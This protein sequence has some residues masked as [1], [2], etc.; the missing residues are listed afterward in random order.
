MG[1]WTHILL[2]LHVCYTEASQVH[3]RHAEGELANCPPLSQPI[4]EPGQVTITVQVVGVETQGPDLWHVVE[5]GDQDTAD[6]VVVKGEDLQ[7][8]QRSEGSIFNAADV[9][10]VQL[11]VLHACDAPER[12]P[13]DALDL[14]FAQI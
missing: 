12:L 4:R 11:Q 5:A 1:T 8:A 7:I 3:R 10:I 14:V 9:V 2:L 6:V 13:R